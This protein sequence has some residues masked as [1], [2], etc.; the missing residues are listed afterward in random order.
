[1]EGKRQL[2]SPSPTRRGFIK[3]DAKE[4]GRTWTGFVLTQDKE[5]WQT[6]VNKV[7]NCLFL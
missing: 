2:G 3:M 7:M 6:G 5:K 4:T 1:M